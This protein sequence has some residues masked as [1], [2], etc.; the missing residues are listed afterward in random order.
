MRHLNPLPTKKRYLWVPVFVVLFGGL[1]NQAVATAPDQCVRNLKSDHIIFDCFGDWA[2]RHV[3][4]RK[5]LAHKYSDATVD[6]SLTDDR[7][8]KFQ[9]NVRNDND[10]KSMPRMVYVINSWID[11]VVIQIDGQTF[12]QKQSSMHTFYGD[13]NKNFISALARA[14]EPIIVKMYYGEDVYKGRLSSKG[15]NAALRWIRAL[16]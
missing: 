7:K 12:T 13:V 15:S 1:I 11:K 2:V 14:E 9:I 8:I 10:A 5:T 3:F 4:N 6:M 16:R